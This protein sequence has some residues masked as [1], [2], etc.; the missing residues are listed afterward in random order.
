VDEG[1]VVGLDETDGNAEGMAEGTK[2]GS[3]E[4]VRLGSFEGMDVGSL[5]GL[6]EGNTD[7]KEDGEEL[8]AFDGILDG[9]TL[10]CETSSKDTVSFNLTIRK[11]VNKAFNQLTISLGNNDGYTRTTEKT[12]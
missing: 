7:G 12:D 1:L 9:D 2:E 4:G 11:V 10:G 3:I 8:G 6:F 5:D